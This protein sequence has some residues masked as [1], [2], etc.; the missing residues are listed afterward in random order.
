MDPNADYSNPLEY[1]RWPG[2]REYI[3]SRPT[4]QQAG[5]DYL[6]SAAYQ[7]AL[8]EVMQQEGSRSLGLSGGEDN[9]Y[10]NPAGA[11][12]PY[13]IGTS[14]NPENP[15]YQLIYWRDGSITQEYAP[16][17]E[18]GGIQAF[19]GLVQ[20]AL[21]AASAYA[22]PAY[23]AAMMG[24]QKLATSGGDI[25]N[26]AL[27][28]ALAAGSSYLAGGGGANAGADISGY[29]A[30]EEA[31]S[32]IVDAQ[33]GWQPYVDPTVSDAPYIPP[34]DM[35]YTLPESTPMQETTIYDDAF[36]N[37]K[38]QDPLVY[39]SD[40]FNQYAK[41]LDLAS[42]KA[43][44]L[45]DRSL[46]GQSALDLSGIPADEW[47][48]Y[49]DSQRT[50]YDDITPQ[51]PSPSTVG[52]VPKA[53]EDITKAAL[54]SALSGGGGSS[55]DIT[56]PQ[57]QGGLFS[58]TQMGKGAYSVNNGLANLMTR[59]KNANTPSFLNNGN[60]YAST[61]KTLNDSLT[62]MQPATQQALNQAFRVT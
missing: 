11:V 23:A 4:L 48:Q 31:L 24:G 44:S 61:L 10:Y 1:F 34:E 21:A 39:G 58:Q 56:L 17:K 5:Q 41:D 9:N 42:E 36:K 54:K 19:K 51:T 62:A 15:D 40:T 25:K 13:V 29:G 7:Q 18:S 8:R 22:G 35:A 60:T 33:S 38:N 59:L 16:D 43:L 26:A 49:T 52:N 12:N 37:L 47:Y 50:G 2:D 14:R 55:G 28:A 27:T 57:G 53:A 45:T 6:Q 30:G 46:G 32:G 20:A 3:D